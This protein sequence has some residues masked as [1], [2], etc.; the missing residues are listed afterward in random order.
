MS[1]WKFAAHPS[2]LGF[3]PPALTCGTRISKPPR[4]L[5]AEA[6]QVFKASPS[7]TSTAPPKAF[8]PL[9]FKASSAELTSSILREHI[10]TST[11]SSA[12]ACAEASPIPLLPPVIIAFISF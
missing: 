1:V 8:T 12:S 5:I 3:P 6:I 4:S 2:S 11:P 9:P 10:A 7:A